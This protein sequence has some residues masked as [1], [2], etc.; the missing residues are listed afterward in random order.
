MNNNK[1][2]AE[3]A[4]RETEV[5]TWLNALEAELERAEGIQT[6]MIARLSCVLHYGQSKEALDNDNN[7]SL[8]P[9]A[10]RIKK[11]S[12]KLSA[13]SDEYDEVLSGIEL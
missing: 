7:D 3:I 8:T 5:S 4:A 11:L 1:S 10:G 9:L 12:D 13:V 2:V 6:K